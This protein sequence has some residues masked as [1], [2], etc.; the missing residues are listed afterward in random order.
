M[1]RSARRTALIVLFAIQPL[2]VIAFWY[3]SSGELLFSNVSG[4]LIALGRLTGLLGALA[5][6]FQFLLI[7]RIRPIENAFGLEALA[8]LHKKTGYYTLGLLLAH[9][10]LLAAGYSAG[11]GTGFIS[12]YRSFITDYPYVLPAAIGMGLL[13]AVVGFSVYIVRKRL[14]YEAWYGI[15]LMSYAVV[16]LAFGHQIA[17]GGTATALPAFRAYWTGLYIAVFGAVAW[18]RFGWPTLLFLRHRFQVSRI[19]QE[20]PS[21]LSIYITG[22]NL[23]RLRARPGQFVIVRFLDRRAW[24]QHPFS[25]SAVPKGD[26]WRITVKGVG[27]FTRALSTL[28][29]GTYVYLDGPFGQFTRDQAV[30]PHRLYIAGGVGITPL[31]SL[32]EEGIDSDDAILLYSNRSRLDIVFTEELKTYEEAGL[33]RVD[34]LSDDPEYPGE[35]GFLDAERIKRLVPDLTEREIFLCGPPP[36]M[37]GLTQTLLGLGVS[38]RRIHAERFAL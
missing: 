30:G 13:V 36:M 7:T 8:K 18:W 16:A 38:S 1:S 12:Q 6:M 4:V 2:I 19:I 23:D 25:L 22:R 28:K 15:H 37:A 21:T 35:K 14:P 20:T 27:D 5:L 17:T 33:R 10:P 9:P 34:V 11:A 32:I 29:E 24:Q 26:T 3:V 31:R